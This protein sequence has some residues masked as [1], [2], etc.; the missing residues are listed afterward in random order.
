MDFTKYMINSLNTLFSQAI[1]ETDENR[2]Y[3]LSRHLSNKYGFG[4]N[5]I[6]TN[7]PVGPNRDRAINSRIDNSLMFRLADA[8]RSF[9]ELMYMFQLMVDKLLYGLNLD[10][11]SRENRDNNLRMFLNNYLIYF[12]R[13]FMG[14]SNDVNFLSDQYTNN[15]KTL[16]IIFCLLFLM[17]T[18]AITTGVR[19]VRDSLYDVNSSIIPYM[20]DFPFE[21]IDSDMIRPFRN[22]ISTSSDFLNIFITMLFQ[23]DGDNVPFD[24]NIYDIVLIV[25]ALENYDLLNKEN[26]IGLFYIIRTRRTHQPH[27]PASDIV[28]SFIR[29]VKFRDT[30]WVV[31][32]HDF[33]LTYGGGFEI[34]DIN[35]MLILLIQLLFGSDG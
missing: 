19:E 11:A 10:G 12:I 30:V 2:L 9:V 24:L 14:N 34:P 3:R 22:G 35:R 13:Y 20:Q 15:L 32:I 8:N 6:L 33:G 18:I 29:S 4:F 1:Q 16:A 28:Y 31:H 23:N 5:D 27:V 21:D 7:Y 17:K 25:K 26:I